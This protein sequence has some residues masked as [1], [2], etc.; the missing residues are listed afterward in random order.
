[1]SCVNPNDPL[2]K[3]LLKEIKNPLLAEIEFDRQEGVESEVEVE[4]EVVGDVDRNDELDSYI[5]NQLFTKL[6]I[7]IPNKNNETLISQ[8][9]IDTFNNAVAMNGNIQ[10][11]EYY[12]GINDAHKWRLNQKNLYDL[13]DATTGDVYLKN[14][15]LSKGVQENVDVPYTPVNE[16][17]RD[18]MIDSINEAVNNYRLD[19]IL[20]EKGYDVNDIIS[21]LEAAS[22]Q[23]ELNSI[24]NKLLNK[25]C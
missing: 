18:I 24:I 10:P 21:N 20:A 11:S 6:G 3:I 9:D 5:T 2:F 4:E 15:N 17:E 23:E 16:E 12:N 7:T 8:A 1:M 22:N 14:I 25:I 13:V 19:E